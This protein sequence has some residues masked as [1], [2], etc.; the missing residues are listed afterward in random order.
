M[1]LS[2]AE[3]ACMILSGRNVVQGVLDV[4]LGTLCHDIGEHVLQRLLLQMLVEHAAPSKL[5]VI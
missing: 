4:K 3:E 5:N 2:N 1:L